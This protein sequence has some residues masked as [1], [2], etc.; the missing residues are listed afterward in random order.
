MA[1]E[2]KFYRQRTVDLFQRFCFTIQTRAFPPV[3]Y[4]NFMFPR[5]FLASTVTCFKVFL[6]S[7]VNLTDE[8]SELIWL[9]KGRRLYSNLGT[10]P[11]SVPK[12]LFDVITLS[13]KRQ[14][15]ALN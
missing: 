1:R 7:C 3:W 8:N 13:D 15:S 6:V 12:I 9:V 10:E 5:K 14:Y 11:V 4:E 2:N